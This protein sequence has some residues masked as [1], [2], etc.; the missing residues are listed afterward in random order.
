MISS[1]GGLDRNGGG[2][3]GVGGRVTLKVDIGHTEHSHIIGKGGNSIK[4]VMQR[5]S[6]HIHFPDSNRTNTEEKSNQVSIAG[7]PMHNVE[8]ARKTLRV[9][10]ERFSLWLLSTRMTAK[11]VCRL[12]RW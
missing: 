7:Y 11:F 10:H 2:G 8:V 12:S 3:G 5:T 1:G 9:R 6:C 4:E